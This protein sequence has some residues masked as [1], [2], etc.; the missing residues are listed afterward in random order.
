MNVIWDKTIVMTL[1]LV[2]IQLVVSYVLVMKDTP[3]VES[4]AMVG[5]IILGRGTML[6]FITAQKFGKV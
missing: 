1:Q 5:Q 6:V 3:E 4:I 2:Q